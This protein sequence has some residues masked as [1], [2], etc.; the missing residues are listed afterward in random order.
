MTH[1]RAQGSKPVASN[2]SQMPGTE[3]PQ[4]SCEVVENFFFIS[5]TSF[6]SLGTTHR[7]RMPGEARTLTVESRCAMALLALRDDEDMD[8]ADDD[9]EGVD[10][11]EDEALREFDLQARVDRIP[12]E[13]W[14]VTAKQRALDVVSG[15]TPIAVRDV[16]G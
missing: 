5:A 14:A 7:G 16:V 9:L 8:D 1:V 15:T 11:E 6:E 2:K 13:E 12:Q 10:D 3:I 4:L